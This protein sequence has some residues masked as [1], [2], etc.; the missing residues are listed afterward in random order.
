MP[1][2]KIIALGINLL[3]SAATVSANK[4]SDDLPTLQWGSCPD[5][6]PYLNATAPIE[7][8]TI[9]LPMDYTEPNSTILWDAPLLRV[10]APKQPSKGSILVNWGGP[11]IPAI[12]STVIRGQE[13]LQCVICTS[14]YS[15]CFSVNM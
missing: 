2:L 11:G 12:P 14:K 1:S 7:C 13:L 4:K 8:A 6:A 3:L 5:A 9:R 10:K 15:C